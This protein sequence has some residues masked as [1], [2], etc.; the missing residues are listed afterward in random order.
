MNN[1]KHLAISLLLS[2]ASFTFIGSIIWLLTDPTTGYKEGIHEYCL[3]F[4]LFGFLLSLGAVLMYLEGEDNKP[5]KKGSHLSVR[6]IREL[7]Y[8][9]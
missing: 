6:D 7:P 3:A 5:H 1:L 9:Y 8:S 4:A 2:I